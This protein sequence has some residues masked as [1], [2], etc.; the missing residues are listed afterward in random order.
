MY[1]SATINPGRVTL[2]DACYFKPPCDS[3]IMISLQP[4][5]FQETEVS[6]S[7]E[8]DMAQQFD[9]DDFTRC[10]ELGGDVDI[11]LGRF[12]TTAGVIVGNDD[13]RS[14]V[15]QC[16]R[17]DNSDGDLIMPRRRTGCLQGTVT[18]NSLT[19]CARIGLPSDAACT[20]IISGTTCPRNDGNPYRGVFK[21][22]RIL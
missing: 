16:I 7:V 5:G 14:P 4:P 6:A 20:A 8:D 18:V 1:S 21:F 13:R 12:D 9:A 3:Q 11:A 15:G 10:F 17:K 2:S 22:S 19:T